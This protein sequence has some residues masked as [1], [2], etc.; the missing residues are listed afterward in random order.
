MLAV[1]TVRAVADAVDAACQA[2][3]TTVA[4]TCPDDATLLAQQLALLLR[5]A[6]RLVDAVSG[7]RQGDAP[8]PVVPAAQ[9]P[10][11]P[12]AAPGPKNPRGT[13]AGRT[14]RLLNELLPNIVI[15]A[16]FFLPLRDLV[17]LDATCQRFHP[18]GLTQ[19][20]CLMRAGMWLQSADRARVERPTMGWP[21]W[22][23]EVRFRGRLRRA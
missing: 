8:A 5:A 6:Q 19:K 21:R 17:A 23:M 4:T 16:S 12:D 11:K 1:P 20:A 22:L 18:V 7:A 15:H 13:R 3:H 2:L 10:A 9:A 14:A